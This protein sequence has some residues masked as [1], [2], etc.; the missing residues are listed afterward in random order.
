MD[1]SIIFLLAIVALLGLMFLFLFVTSRRRDAERAVDAGP[2]IEERAEM[3][4]ANLPVPV[5]HASASG[6]EL[7]R[8]AALERRGSQVAAPDAPP[9][10]LPAPL[11]EEAL[12]VTRRQVLNRGIIGTFTLAITGFGAACVAML[13][14][15]LSGGFGSKIRVGKFDEIMDEIADKKEPYYVG[16]GRTYISPYPQEGVGAAK[17][18]AAYSAVLEGYE[19][20]VVALYQKC[21]HLG[22]RVPWCQSSQWYECPCHGSQYNRVGE[23][24]GGP[25]PRGMDRF[26]AT[27]EN[28]VIIVDTKTVIPGPPIGTNTTGQEA[29]GPNCIGAVSEH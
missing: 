2:S 27:V 16:A 17:N 5:G 10:P 14:P 6:R 8:A 9:A 25:A 28:G 23:K 7:E 13:W 12:G 3:A 20:G 1:S 24:K 21:P 18:V 19:Q 26:A 11:D 4:T 29:E 15:S 22:C